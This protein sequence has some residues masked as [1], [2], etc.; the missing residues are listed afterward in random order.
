MAGKA[1]L[2]EEKTT[3][4]ITTPAPQKNIL[5]RWSLFF[6]YLL[7]FPLLLQLVFG[8]FSFSAE[9]FLNW[10][11][12]L[13]LRLLPAAVFTAASFHLP[14]K[15]APV[16]MGAICMVTAFFNLLDIFLLVHFGAV[17]DHSI[18]HLMRIAPKEEVQGFF[19]LF[20][21][22][23][24]SWIILL[25][26]PAAGFIIFKVRKRRTLW[27]ILLLITAV[28]I[29]FFNTVAPARKREVLP[30]AALMQDLVR[31]WKSSELKK[32]IAAASRSITAAAQDQESLILL[33]IG[34]SH[35]R[36]RSS[37]Y[38]SARDTMPQLKQLHAQGKLHL[39]EDAVTPH[40]MTHL[41]LP[42]LLTLAGKD[43]KNFQ[44]YPT[45]PD[46]FRKAN[47]KVWYIYN[48]M[49]D[50]E[51]Y[52]PFLAAA[53][54]SNEFISLSAKEKVHDSAMFPAVKKILS[55]PAPKKLV[56]VHLRGNHW[57]YSATFPQEK[58]F[59]SRT[60]AKDHKEKVINEYDDSLRFLDE[61]LAALIALAESQ[62]KNSFLLYLP[63]HGEALY[64]EENFVGHTDLFPT[65]ATAELPMFIWFSEEFG[66][67][68]LMAKVKQVR[69]QPFLS[70]DLP[71]LLMEIAGIKTPAFQQERS[72]LN[73]RYR[74]VKRTV[75][76]SS[77]DYDTMKNRS[78]P[79]STQQ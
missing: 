41:A 56:I 7:F 5:R 15:A 43:I 51:K 33:V 32:T 65:A 28:V 12:A 68:E 21:M 38:G 70:S 1:G 31:S 25:L 52:L 30:P 58:R 69:K 20:F 61:N 22:R 73:S 29:F 37:L 39:F 46:I 79:T 55:D 6:T 66:S 71:H 34:E 75:S 24:S 54:R 19:Q 63:D 49:P 44:N 8:I 26:Y 13:L 36:R 10:G 17:F 2:M 14:R 3:P 11:G 50:D 67:P 64:E 45:I 47:F 42:G 9:D 4:Q 77:V 27:S 23:F 59:F 18:L 72:L 53:K 40:V 57:I 16:F 74:K 78:V 76:T 62:K 60:P 35:S 48:Q